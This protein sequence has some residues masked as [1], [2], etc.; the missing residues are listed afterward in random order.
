MNK[1]SHLQHVDYRMRDAIHLNDITVSMTNQF[2][3]Q[4]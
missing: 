3:T 1:V 2:L 4:W